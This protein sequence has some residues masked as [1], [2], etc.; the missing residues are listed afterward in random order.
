MYTAV[1]SAEEENTTEHEL[2]ESKYADDHKLANM[3]L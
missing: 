2:S 3:V 1:M